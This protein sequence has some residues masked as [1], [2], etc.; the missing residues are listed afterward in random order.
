MKKILV[1]L[2]KAKSPYSGLGQ[3]S[4]QFAQE[5]SDNYCH[6]FEFHF[7]MPRNYNSEFSPLIKIINDSPL[8]RLW[9]SSHEQYDL[10]HSLYQLPSHR[11]PKNFKRLITIHDLNFLIEKEGSKKEKYLNKLIKDIKSVDYI[12]T[13]SN[14]SKSQIEAYLPV[15]SKPIKVIHNGV[16]SLPDLRAKKPTFIS[17]MKDKFFFSISLFSAKKNLEVLLPVM[18]NFPHYKLILAGNCNNA[19]GNSLKQTISDLNLQNQILLPGKIT[20][21][22][23]A[24]LF[25][26][27]HA[28]FFPSKAEGFGMPVIEAMQFGKPVFISNLT[29]L[30]EIGGDA[31]YYFDSFDPG[32]MTTDINEGL[33]SHH[34]NLNEREWRIMVQ[35]ERFTWRRSM[36][37]YMDLYHQII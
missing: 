28:F 29:S 34:E 30:P 26:H 31:A 2:Y 5:I 18:K 36:A 14:Y 7:L 27:C 35:A 9:K 20:D 32:K 1:D 25:E 12:S 10:W 19:Y 17:S 24:F 16:K 4:L 22:E 11:P 37:S 23:K 15:N 8:L 33:K 3:F 6:N 13:I 21:A